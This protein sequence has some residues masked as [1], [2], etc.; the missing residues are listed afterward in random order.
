LCDLHLAP[1][2]RVAGGDELLGRPHAPRLVG[3]AHRA[4]PHSAH[5]AQTFPG[6]RV[7]R[8]RR[9]RPNGDLRHARRRRDVAA[10]RGRRLRVRLEQ[11]AERHVGE[12]VLTLRA[13]LGPQVEGCKAWTGSEAR[14]PQ[15]DCAEGHPELLPRVPLQQP[16]A[17]LDEAAQRPVEEGIEQRLHRRLQRRAAVVGGE[18]EGGAQ[19]DE[20]QVAPRGQQQLQRRSGGGGDEAAEVLQPAALLDALE[21]LLDRDPYGRARR[22]NGGGVERGGGRGGGGGGGGGAGGEVHHSQHGL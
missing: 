19:A 8:P 6:H 15:L 16:V 2:Q 7:H 5:K 14:V 21:S 10:E 4:H 20:T 18:G 11:P 17:P 13:D 3:Q 1:A 9:R 12:V 22:R